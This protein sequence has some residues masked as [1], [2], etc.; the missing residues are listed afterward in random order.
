MDGMQEFV[1]KLTWFPCIKQDRVGLY[2]RGYVWLRNNMIKLD[3]FRIYNVE[4]SL[5]HWWGR[6]HRPGCGA[7]CE[8]GGGSGERGG[9]R[10]RASSGSSSI[11]RTIGN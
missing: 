1:F 3:Q 11:S 7:S 8:G 5:T 2:A 10:V 9:G 6:C 4:R